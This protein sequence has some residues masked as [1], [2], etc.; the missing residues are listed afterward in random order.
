[1]I[2]GF[3]VPGL[4]AA[5]VRAQFM[6][7]R[8]P[9]TTEA[10]LIYIALST[11]YLAIAL[12]ILELLPRHP[13]GSVAA[14]AE[15]VVLVFFGPALLGLSLGIGTRFGVV[16]RLLL[17]LRLNP[18]HPMPTAWDYK[19]TELSEAWVLVK[20]KDGTKF[21]GFCGGQSFISSVPEER[22]I[23]V[24]QIYDLSDDDEWIKRPGKSLL[25]AA[26][27]ISTIEFFNVDRREHVERPE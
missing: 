9:R 24:E 6:T 8:L 14:T 19:F 3:V 23:Y 21:A 10:G 20:L 17:W 1:M 16:R 13:S 27:E 25:V 22:D 26:G 12:P 4:V 11:I 7:G 5:M 2:V 18:V 15:W